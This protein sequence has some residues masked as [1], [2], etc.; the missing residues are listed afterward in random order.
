M[1][2]RPRI[3]FAMPWLWSEYLI[4][5]HHEKHCVGGHL[6]VRDNGLYIADKRAILARI[7]SDI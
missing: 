1:R 4:L 5:L 3:M 7:V 2:V 6:L